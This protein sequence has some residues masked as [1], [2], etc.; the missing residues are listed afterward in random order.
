M[1]I[2]GTVFNILRYTLD[3]GPGIRSTVFLKGCPLSCPWCANPESQK[4]YPEIG[5]RKAL[6]VRCGRC[7]ASC[8][9]QAITLGEKHA[10]IDREKCRRCQTCVNACFTK[11]LEVMG[12]PM[13]VEDV[14]KVVKKDMDY[15]EESGG[16]VTV[17]GGEPLMQP[18]FLAAFLKKLKEE[19]IHTCVDTTGFC[20]REVLE[21]VLPYVDLFYFDIK[22]MDSETHR[23]VVGV[24]TE[25]IHENLRLIAERGVK[26]CIRVPCIPGFNDN[27]TNM[28][29]MGRFVSEILPGND[30]HL[31][32][33]HR[34]GEGKY[35]MIGRSYPMPEVESPTQERLE[36]F[37][38]ILDGFGLNCIIHQ[39]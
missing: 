33:Y 31:L 17:S 24:P 15:Y 13:S 23:N 36:E 4:T 19:G 34:Y 32:P 38:K 9:N 35:E 20:D 39:K 16:G 2:T 22:H 28:E 10:L 18:E 21:Q 25:P 27:E 8:P 7:A 11:T 26:V 37:K 14:W 3:D 29:A 12:K 1:S 6:C 30:I 5:M